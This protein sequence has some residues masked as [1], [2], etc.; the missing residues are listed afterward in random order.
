MQTRKR[1]LKIPE[2]VQKKCFKNLYDKIKGQITD[3]DRKD[4]NRLIIDA[5]VRRK[6]TDQEFVNIVKSKIKPILHR[7]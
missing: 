2:N 1:K 7:Q 6:F 5:Y 4:L 3:F